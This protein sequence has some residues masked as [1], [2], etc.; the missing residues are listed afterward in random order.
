MAIDELERKLRPP[1]LQMAPYPAKVITLA[2]GKK[3]PNVDDVAGTGIDGGIEQPLKA[4]DILYVPQS[5]ILH[6]L[7][8]RK[9]NR[10]FSRHRFMH[11]KTMA[12]FV[13]KHW[14]HC[15]QF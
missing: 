6:H 13:R 4:G 12:H 15:L 9:Y 11:Y 8:D 2:N 5:V 7:D 14:R 3:R 1:E 10:F